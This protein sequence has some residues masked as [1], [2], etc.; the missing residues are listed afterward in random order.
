[1]VKLIQEVGDFELIMERPISFRHQVTQTT[2]LKT[3]QS[4]YHSET[5]VQKV[6]F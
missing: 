1:M 4:L 6:R 5:Y 3:I 2:R